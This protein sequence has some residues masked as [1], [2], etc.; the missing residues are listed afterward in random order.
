ML[1]SAIVGVSFIGLTIVSCGESKKEVVV[2]TTPK[3]EVQKIGELKIAYYD[4]D[5]MKANFKYYKEQDAIVTKR[6]LAFQNS[7]E[8]KRKEMET[9]YNNFMKKAQ[10]NELSQV[11]SEGYQRNLQNQEAALM[12][13]QEQEGAKIEKETLEKLES[14]GNKI[15]QFS[16]KYCEEN[17]IDILLIYAKGGQFNYI[18]PSMNVTTEFTAYL[19]QNQEQI[20]KEV[21]KK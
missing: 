1:K 9:Y 2:D 17:G 18:N 13:Y 14:I 15:E 11:E 19:N 7:L 8:K 10:N 3:V 12:Q 5:S 16:K 6:Q 20:Q 21:N 4:Q